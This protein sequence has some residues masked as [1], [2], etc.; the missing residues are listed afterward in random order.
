MNLFFFCAELGYHMMICHDCVYHSSVFI[1]NVT[2]SA[3]A[4]RTS[5]IHFTFSL[6]A[7]KKTKGKELICIQ[8]TSRKQQAVMNSITCKKISWPRCHSVHDTSQ[9]QINRGADE[10]RMVNKMEQCF[11]AKFL[12]TSQPNKKTKWLTSSQVWDL[13]LTLGWRNTEPFASIWPA[14]PSN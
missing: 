8:S 3:S 10:R 11:A 7:V 6:D 1:P 12:W 2:D 14:A 9:K 5:W 4:S 13:T